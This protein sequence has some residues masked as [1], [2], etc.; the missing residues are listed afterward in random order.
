MMTLRGQ[1]K[2]R[3]TETVPDRF[4][5]TLADE[6]VDVDLPVDEL[7]TDLKK[8]RFT[9]ETGLQRRFVISSNRGSSLRFA[10][11]PCVK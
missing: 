2:V 4:L 5:D 10:N 3:V 9:H 7:L 6:I 11:S 8:G 1:R